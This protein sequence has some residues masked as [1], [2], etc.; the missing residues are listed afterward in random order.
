[1]DQVVPAQEKA[2][3]STTGAHNENSIPKDSIMNTVPARI[4]DVTPTGAMYLLGRL[5]ARIAAGG[6][7]P[8]QWQEDLEAAIAFQARMEPPC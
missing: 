4:S 6:L 2:P 8:E 5:D 7:T 1:M 3:V